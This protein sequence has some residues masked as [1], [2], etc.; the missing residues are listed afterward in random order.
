LGDILTASPGSWAG[1]PTSFS[2]QWLNNGTGIDGA[3]SS[4]YTVQ[5]GDVGWVL[6]VQVTAGN[7]IG[8]SAPATSA[9]T[10][11]VKGNPENTVAPQVTSSGDI[12]NPE[13]GEVLSTDNGTWLGNPTTF[14]YQWIYLSE[15]EIGGATSNTYTVQSSDEGNAIACQI[16]ASNAYA[17]GSPVNSN[18]TGTVQ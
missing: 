5:L 7:A 18:A 12:N 10:A 14:N 6:S 16:I 13:P 1:S 2:Y 3:T 11:I 17:S 4:L 8:D 9:A 15:A